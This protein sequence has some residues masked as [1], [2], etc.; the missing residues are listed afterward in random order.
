MVTE[1]DT[2]AGLLVDAEMAPPDPLPLPEPH[3]VSRVR[4]PMAARAA[5]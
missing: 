3:A 4:D 5:A 1:P 2:D